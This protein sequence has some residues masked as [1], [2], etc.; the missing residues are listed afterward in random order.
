MFFFAFL[1]S[2]GW[3]RT[4]FEG[5]TPELVFAN[6]GGWSSSPNAAYGDAYIKLIAFINNEAVDGMQCCIFGYD[7]SVEGIVNRIRL[8]ATEFSLQ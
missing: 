7:K 6:R 4:P 3:Y 5:A 2:V 8:V 1:V